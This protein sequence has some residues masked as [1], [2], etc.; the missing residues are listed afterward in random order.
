M[1]R[2]EACAVGVSRGTAFYTDF[3]DD[4]DITWSNESSPMNDGRRDPETYAVIGAAMEVHRQLGHGFLEAVYQ[5]A[6]AREFT[7]REIPFKREVM[8]SIIYKGKPLDMKYMADFICYG[9]LIVE[10]KAQS[11]LM[12]HDI[13]QT[14]NYLKAT[15]QNLGLLINFGNKSLETKRLIHSA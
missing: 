5:E 4:A 11:C 8:L 2:A 1:D 7:E 3:A 9:H 15:Q 12:D 10:T 6:L 13:G 14:V